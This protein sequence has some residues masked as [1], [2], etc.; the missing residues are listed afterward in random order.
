[1]SSLSQH[2]DFEIHYAV[3]CISSSFFLKRPLLSI[4]DIL[5]CILLLVSI[6]LYISHFVYSTV[7]QWI[8]S[9]SFFFLFFLA[10]GNK[11]AMKKYLA[12]EG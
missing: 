3:M 5:K 10:I 4:K 1:M 7:V 6:L 11:A 8:V 2:K 9:S 12:V